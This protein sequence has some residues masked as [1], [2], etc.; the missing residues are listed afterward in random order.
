MN[1]FAIK[2]LSI[3]IGTLLFISCA[4]EENKTTESAEKV[5]EKV[6][7]IAH[8]YDS[9]WVLFT[10]AVNEGAKNEVIA[11]V[12]STNTNLDD[13]VALN[14]EYFFDDVFKEQIKNL[15]YADLETGEY[16]NNPAKLVK[17]T[18]TYTE[19]DVELDSMYIFYF[20][21]TKDGLKI[22]HIE[23]AG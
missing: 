23:I 20:A 3:L 12:D 1:R 8:N 17:I 21:E 19:G 22:V 15:N 11:F 4:T 13:E 2:S 6:E 18:H 5:E 14:Y 7:E 9:E 16:E 10:E